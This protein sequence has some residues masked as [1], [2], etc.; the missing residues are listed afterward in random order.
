MFSYARLLPCYLS[1]REVVY[2]LSLL[3][4]LQKH[5]LTQTLLFSKHFVLSKHN[6]RRRS[7]RDII[8]KSRMRMN[9]IT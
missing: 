3:P 1:G 8:T 9:T 4:S 2:C 5:T 7:I 6:M